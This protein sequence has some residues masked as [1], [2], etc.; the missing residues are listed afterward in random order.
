MSTRYT[1]YTIS[2]TLSTISTIITIY[3]TIFIYSS[4]SSSISSIISRCHG[5]DLILVRSI[6]AIADDRRHVTEV[7]KVPLTVWP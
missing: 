1:N 4:I 3:S 2:T 5:V 7:A 6:Y